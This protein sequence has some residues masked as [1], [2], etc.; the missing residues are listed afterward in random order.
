MHACMHASLWCMLSV[1]LRAGESLSATTISSVK[2]ST[3][4]FLQ[5]VSKY[6]RLNAFRINLCEKLKASHKFYFL[7]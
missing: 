7:C 2:L 6:S 4:M 3:N 1:D 5:V